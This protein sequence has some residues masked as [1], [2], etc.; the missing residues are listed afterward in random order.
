MAA[1]RGGAI[2]AAGLLAAALLAFWPSYLSRRGAGFT[3]YVHV[4]ATAMTLWFALS[5]ARSLPHGRDHQATN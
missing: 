1:P 2:L 5:A 4:H 3:G